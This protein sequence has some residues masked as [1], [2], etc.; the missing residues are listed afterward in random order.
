MKLTTCES[1]YELII[2][3]QDLNIIAVENKAE[4]QRVF[5]AWIANYTP[6]QIRLANNARR[7]L[8]RQA[9]AKK[10]AHPR[11]AELRKIA[12]DRQVKAP[13]QPFAIFFSERVSTGV[14]KNIKVVDAM[15]LAREEFKALN[16]SEQRV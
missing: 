3:S 10:G 13:L 11:S 1:E 16:S 7:A 5:D 9:K 6:E 2:W 8:R 15:R 4:N 12:D 14:F